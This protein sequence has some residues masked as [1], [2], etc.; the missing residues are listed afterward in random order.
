MIRAIAFLLPLGLLFGGA[1]GAGIQT[2]PENLVEFRVPDGWAV[3]DT[4]HGIRFGRAASPGERTILSVK[5]SRPG[6]TTTLESLR[7]LALSQI[8]S[9]ELALVT[10]KMQVVNGWNAWESVVDTSRSTPGAIMHSFRMLAK[11]CDV[12]VKLM[13]AKADYPRYKADLL[14]LVQSIRQKK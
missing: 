2:D 10:D 14:A 8:R 5:A 4:S 3:K 6:P 13:A 1:S 11:D 9:Q 7:A 12:D